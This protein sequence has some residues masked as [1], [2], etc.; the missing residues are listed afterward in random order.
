MSENRLHPDDIN[1]IVNGITAKIS[2]HYCRFS[3]IKTED[4]AAVIPFMMKFKGLSEKVGS[5]VLYVVVT[6]LSGGMI[7][8]FLKGL[9]ARIKGD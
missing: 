7:A 3:S 6:I 1:K 4:M 9:W 2:D 5:I 8:I